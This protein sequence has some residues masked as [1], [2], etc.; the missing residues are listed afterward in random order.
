[1]ASFR[2]TVRIVDGKA[3]LESGGVT[4]SLDGDMAQLR[5]LN[6]LFTRL[7]GEQTGDVIRNATLAPN[8]ET[9]VAESNGALQFDPVIAAIKAQEATWKALPGVMG[10]RPGFHQR[11]GETTAVPAIVV[12]TESTQPIAGLPGDVD[13]IPVEQRGATVFEATQGFLP[14]AAW[15]RSL[16]EAAPNIHYVPPADLQLT[17]H[18]VHNIT[19]HIGP[20]SGWSTLKPF[21]EGTTTSLTVA[22]YEFYADHIIDTVT[23]LGEESDATLNIILQVS[24]ND[25]N[26][27]NV[28]NDSWGN[29]LSFTPALVSG[30]NR[31]FNNSYHTKIAVRDS[32]AFWQSSGNWS[33]NS[34]PLISPGSEQV[35]YSKGNREWHVV[36]EDAPLS[37]LLEKFIQ[38][39]VS[40]AQ[41]GG[42]PEAAAE[43]PD[44]LIPEAWLTPE[45]AV[46][47]D[48]PFESK[49]FATTGPAVRVEPLM[50]PDNYAD[51]ILELINSAEHSLYLQFSYIR[52]PSREKFDTIIS[53]IAQRMEDDID[54][55]I[56]VG[57]NQTPEHSD[58][59]IGVR[60]WKRTMFRR[61]TSKVHNKGI[62]VDGK[63]AVVGS[64]NWSTDG[65]Q[66]N[67]D[68]SLIFHS[69]PIAQY[70]TEV[71]LF[72]WD[73]LSKSIGGGHELAP[74][75]APESGP[76][77]LGMVRIPWQAWFDE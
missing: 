41:T 20:D 38:Y 77:P 28:L 8:A 66:Y 10:V 7:T 42:A 67:R 62:L 47:Q 37:Q 63:I 27:E 44:L 74:E 65:T 11:D 71:F 26:M 5:P 46:V 34:Q 25:N 19:C 29:R 12:V 50:S 39:D 43:M 32:S 49:T 53:A 1:M 18:N 36:I 70:F 21:L 2:G 33:P 14:L 23:R 40:Q 30:P 6:G 35:L 68:S 4:V 16:P 48:H 52:Q 17:P 57:P 76:T 9:L 69:R 3:T 31:I 51:R 24:A 73:N 58:L 75:L 22:M 61:Q 60:G 13:G 56:L 64:N 72:D 55:R 59:L 45:A 54:V 15:E